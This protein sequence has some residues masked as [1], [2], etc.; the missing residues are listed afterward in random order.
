MHR[1][2]VFIA[3]MK[4]AQFFYVGDDDDLPE[5][6]PTFEIWTDGATEI[7]NRLYSRYEMRVYIVTDLETTEDNKHR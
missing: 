3:L 1:I 2:D 5:N 7:N 4:R 6:L